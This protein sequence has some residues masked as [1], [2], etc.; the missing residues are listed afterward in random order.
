MTLFQGKSGLGRKNYVKEKQLQ[1]TR[2]ESSRFTD[3]RQRKQDVFLQRRVEGDLRKS[4][5][6]CEQLD[7]AK[8]TVLMP[9]PTFSLPIL[10]IPGDIPSR[11]ELVLASRADFCWRWGGGGGRG[12]GWGWGRRCRRQWLHYRCE[13]WA[14]YINTGF[15]PEHYMYVRVSSRKILLGW[16]LHTE[17]F[18]EGKLQAYIW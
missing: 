7:S 4:Q 3:F 1:K 6:A 15:S 2:Q 17:N 12:R 14:D 13:C 11:T 8:V 10:F 18:L 5:M 9:G 16:K